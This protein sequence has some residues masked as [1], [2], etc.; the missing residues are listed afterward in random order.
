MKPKDDEIGG[1]G[2]CGDCD[3]CKIAP[4]ERENGAAMTQ[5]VRMRVSDI[6]ILHELRENGSETPG[7][8][9]HRIIEAY[10][11]PEPPRY[12]GGEFP[13]D[14]ETIA[15]YEKIINKQKERIGVLQRE[16]DE[17]KHAVRVLKSSLDDSI[18][19]HG[20]IRKEFEGDL[21]MFQDQRESLLETIDQMATNHVVEIAEKD[22]VIA[23]LDVMFAEHSRAVNKHVCDG[24]GGTVININVY[25]GSRIEEDTVVVSEG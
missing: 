1:Q 21:T 6:T 8:V 9:I 12:E 2:G 20:E 18:E 13:A 10:N 5:P 15:K 14:D 3:L 17:Q 24:P 4:A 25:K 19:N 23:E 11:T 7:G 22:R 16:I